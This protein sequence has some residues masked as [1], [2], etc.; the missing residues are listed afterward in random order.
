MNWKDA[1]TFCE[2]HDLELAIL[3][4]EDEMEVVSNARPLDG[5]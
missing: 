3:K 1:K 5:K 4:S 2:T